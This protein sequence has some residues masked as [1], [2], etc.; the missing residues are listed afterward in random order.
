M[1]IAL[2]K[3][4]STLGC[5][6]SVCARV[7]RTRRRDIALSDTQP[8][9]RTAGRAA[10]A[11]GRSALHA[12]AAQQGRWATP[13]STSLNVS[14]GRCTVG[15][16]AG[17]LG[18]SAVHAARSPGRRSAIRNAGRWAT[19]QLWTM[20]STMD[21]ASR[22]LWLMDSAA[23]IGN[24]HEVQEEDAHESIVELTSEELHGCNDHLDN[25]GHNTM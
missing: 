10:R 21:I 25:N 24:A 17:A 4:T 7:T 12:A 22:E 5:R 19:P 14:Q 8:E 13:S 1:E 20:P 23:S 16:A 2:H 11:L 18:R 3:G 6:S 9:R 15:R